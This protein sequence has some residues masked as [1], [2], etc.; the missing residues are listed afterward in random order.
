MSE[1]ETKLSEIGDVAALERLSAACGAIRR[2][3]ARVIVGQ[4][5]VIEQLLVAMLAGGIAC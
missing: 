4:D 2:E 1:S 5:R 3:L